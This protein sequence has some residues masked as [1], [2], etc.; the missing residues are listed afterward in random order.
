MVVPEGR[1]ACTV[2]PE[3]QRAWSFNSYSNNCLF[4]T[5]AHKQETPLAMD[6][7][8]ASARF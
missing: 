7:D 2:P 1:D 6:T 8:R 3:G 5:V 4:V